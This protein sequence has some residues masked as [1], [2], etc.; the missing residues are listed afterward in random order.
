MDPKAYDQMAQVE[1]IH[2]WFVARRQILS[3][4]IQSIQLPSQAQILEAGC[5]SGGNLAMLSAFGTISGM[6]MS[7]MA[8][9]KAQARGLGVIQ[10]GQLPHGIPFE[11]QRF[12][13]IALLDVLEHLE[14]DQVALRA[15]AS[16]LTAQGSLLIAVPAN[17]WLWSRHDDINHH[18][19]RYTRAQLRQVI[20][21]AGLKLERIT[22]FNTLLFPLIAAIRLAQK[23]FKLQ[24]SDDLTLPSSTV[25]RI[26]TWIFG[27]ERLWIT[28]IPMPFGV[29]LLAVARPQ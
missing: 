22:Y 12:H 18:K 5:G 24:D 13:L 15:L 6:E 28:R 14:E 29:S 19:R 20:E 27:L 9:Q 16:R 11:G 25:N 26:L 7:D 23:Q 10:S 3:R 4:V 2:W 8:R 17:P 21:Q 1:D